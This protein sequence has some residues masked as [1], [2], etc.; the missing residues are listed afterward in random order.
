MERKREHRDNSSL[1][2]RFQN[3]MDEKFVFQMMC[4]LAKSAASS[5]L[6][7]PAAQHWLPAPAGVLQGCL[8]SFALVFERAV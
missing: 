5:R 2:S 4:L 6:A 7:P 3:C 1:F 8:L